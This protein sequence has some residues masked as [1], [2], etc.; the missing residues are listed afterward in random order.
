MAFAAHLIDAVALLEEKTWHAVLMKSS[1][2][3]KAKTTMVR[4]GLCKHEK[5]EMTSRN[6]HR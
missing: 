5:V 3:S 2:A 1:M 4:C 6:E